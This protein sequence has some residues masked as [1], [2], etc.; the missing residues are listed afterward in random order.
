MALAE[1]DLMT[2]QQK[3]ELLGNLLYEVVKDMELK[4]GELAP[5]L[6]AFAEQHEMGLSSVQ[7]IYYEDVKKRMEGNHNETVAEVSQEEQDVNENKDDKS[8]KKDQQIVEKAEGYLEKDTDDLAQSLRSPELRPERPPYKEGT[9]MKVQAVN[10]RPYGVIVETQDGYKYSGLLHISEIKNGYVDSVETYFAERDIFDAKV[11]R[12]ETDGKIAFTTKGMTV[13]LKSTP[14]IHEVN[15]QRPAN[16]ALA[17][18]IMKVKDKIVTTDTPVAPAPN[19]ALASNALATA[20]HAPTKPK[21]EMSNEYLVLEKFL[22]SHAG[23]VV[24]AEA[25]EYM[26]KVVG[27]SG[28]VMLTLAMAKVAQTWKVDPGVMFLKEAEQLLKD[29]R[30]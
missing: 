9:V 16:N 4:R 3:N 17:N 18:E 13:T 6:K 21:P 30:L 20:T 8:A 11:K 22:E 1:T 5:L 19:L 10:I 28:I 29:G 27:E 14:T 24:S 25:K 7:R 2:T 23:S 26:L 12:V 15:A